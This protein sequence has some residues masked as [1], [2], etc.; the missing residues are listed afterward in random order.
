MKPKV[1]HAEKSVVK[2][3]K[4]RPDQIEADSGDLQ[5]KPM[6]LAPVG[7]KQTFLAAVTAGADAVY[8]GLKQF[9]ARMAAVNFT[10]EELAPLAA[11][12]VVGLAVSLY[13]L[14]CKVLVR[15]KRFRVWH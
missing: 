9:S 4:K 6:I 15:R 12:G 11:L 3:R 13:A 14:L 8:C 7:N 1:A 5:Q 2:R 10:I